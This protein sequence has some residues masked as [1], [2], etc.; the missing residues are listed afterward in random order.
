MKKKKIKMKKI[1]LLNLTFNISKEDLDLMKN[2]TKTLYISTHTYDPYDVFGNIL[3]AWKD[4]KKKYY[5]I[6]S[7]NY[8]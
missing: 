7:K 6:A 1:R 8:K 2:N 3:T 4:K 5:H